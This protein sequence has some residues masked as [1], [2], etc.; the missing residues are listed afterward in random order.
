MKYSNDVPVCGRKNGEERFYVFF[1]D[2][3]NFSLE[4]IYFYKVKCVR[5][6]YDKDIS[7]FVI[8]G[9]ILEEYFT[10]GNIGKK[11]IIDYTW[12]LQKTK[13]AAQRLLIHLIMNYGSHLS[14]NDT[15]P[16]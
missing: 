11:I 2:Y 10:K 1:T 6:W 5:R 14:Y 4:D 12:Q 3:N 15:L 7:R 9:I 16:I 8:D 13:E